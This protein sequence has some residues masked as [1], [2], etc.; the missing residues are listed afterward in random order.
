MLIWHG[1]KIMRRVEK[2]AGRLRLCL[3]RTVVTNARRLVPVRTGDLKGTIRVEEEGE[4]VMVRAGD[5]KVDYA[6][7]VELGTDRQAAQPYLRPAGEQ[8]SQS[9]VSKCIR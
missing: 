1:N 5:D 6:G 9:D 2:D 8:V 7:K 3:G 4:A